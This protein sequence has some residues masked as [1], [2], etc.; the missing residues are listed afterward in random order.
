WYRKVNCCLRL[1]RDR[2]RQ[3]WA[4]RMVISL[5]RKDS[6][7]RSSRNCRKRR[8]NSHRQIVS[9]FRRRLNLPRQKL[10]NKKHSSTS[11]NTRRSQRKRPLADKISTTQSRPTLRRGPR[12]KPA[13]RGL[14]QRRPRSKRPM[15][16]LELPK[17]QSQPPGHRWSHQKLPC[18]PLN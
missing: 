18:G 6:L 10:T 14:N 2:S 16:E 5:R 4:R 12:L 11:I 13:K 1:T 17:P 9:C 15:R 8:H 3:H 7:V